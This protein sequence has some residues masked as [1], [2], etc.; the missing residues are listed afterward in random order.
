[1]GC[2]KMS[3]K[4][5]VKKKLGFRD[6]TGKDEDNIPLDEGVPSI[7]SDGN[8]LISLM[9]ISELVNMGK[10]KTVSRLKIEQIPNITKLYLFSQVF[11]TDYTK[12]LADNILQLQISIKGLGRRE[13][14]SLVQQR[15]NPSQ[16]VV[17]LSSKDIFK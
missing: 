9:A 11:D 6:L 12:M 14:V 5:N 15:D 4:D 7:D 13:L 16:E 17:K 8:D 10:L 3:F 1:M 2:S